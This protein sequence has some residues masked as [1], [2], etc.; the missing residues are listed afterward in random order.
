MA[1]KIDLGVRM[2]EAIEDNIFYI[3]SDAFCAPMGHHFV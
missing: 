2:C 3:L 1:V